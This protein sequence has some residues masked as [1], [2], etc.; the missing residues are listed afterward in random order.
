MTVLAQRFTL[1]VYKELL[2]LRTKYVMASVYKQIYT[3][4]DI[5]MVAFF[6]GQKKR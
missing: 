5:L 3:F 4:A 1:F 6:G 2:F